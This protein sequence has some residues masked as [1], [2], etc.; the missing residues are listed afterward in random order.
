MMIARELSGNQ[1]FTFAIKI[2]LEKEEG[3]REKKEGSRT[4][5]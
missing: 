1:I 4:R 3:E 5:N 2:M